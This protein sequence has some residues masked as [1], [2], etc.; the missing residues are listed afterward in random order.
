MIHWRYKRRS[1]GLIMCLLFV[2]AAVARDVPSG[3]I[4]L[5]ATSM[6]AGVGAQWGDG[7]LTLNNGK[8]YRFAIQGLE[9]GG[10]GFADLHAQGTV[11]NLRRVSDLDGLYVAADANVAV[12]SGPGTQTMRNE[13]GVVINLSSEQQG[14]KL[15]LGGQGVRITLKNR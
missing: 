15:T 14:V 12:G 10:V 11:Y 2:S 13:H 6:A 4:S 8:T 1:L 3:T 7:T 9:V 5:S